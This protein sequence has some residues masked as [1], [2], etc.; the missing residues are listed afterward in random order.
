MKMIIKSAVAVTAICLLAIF[1][2]KIISSRESSGG[3]D[4]SYLT[5]QQSGGAN[6]EQMAALQTERLLDNLDEIASR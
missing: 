5:G 1:G 2:A 4:Q 6:T 3:T